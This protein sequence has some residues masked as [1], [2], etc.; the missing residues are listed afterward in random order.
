MARGINRVILIGNLGAD[1]EVKYT[2]A[3]ATVLHATTLRVAMSNRRSA[4]K[5][6][7]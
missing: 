4:Q 6:A 2:A 5:V 1:P 7:A 3:A